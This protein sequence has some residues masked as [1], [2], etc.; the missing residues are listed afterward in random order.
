MTPKM[1][2]VTHT[3]NSYLCCLVLKTL[4]RVLIFYILKLII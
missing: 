1:S 2:R 3:K 4:H